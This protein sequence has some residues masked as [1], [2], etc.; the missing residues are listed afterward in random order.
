MQAVSSIAFVSRF[1]YYEGKRVTMARKSMQMHINQISI[2]N[3]HWKTKNEQIRIFWLN[4]LYLI[5]IEI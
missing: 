3:L 4:L 5:V 1:T 2:L